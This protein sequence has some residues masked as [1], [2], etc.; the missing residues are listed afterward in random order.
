MYSESLSCY[1]LPVST[2]SARFRSRTKNQDRTRTGKEP[3]QQVLLSHLASLLPDEWTP[4]VFSTQEPP[5][6]WSRAVRRR[7]SNLLLHLGFCMGRQGTL[8]V[9]NW[10]EII[11]QN[12]AE[13]LLGRISMRENGQ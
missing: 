3:K 13:M 2:G 1:L 11:H 5:F 6:D 9:Y 8:A 7:I 12:E 10:V 4:T